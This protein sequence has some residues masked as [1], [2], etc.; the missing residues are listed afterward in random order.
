MPVM[1]GV[2]SYMNVED[3]RSLSPCAKSVLSWER[4][5]TSASISPFVSNQMVLFTN[6]IWHVGG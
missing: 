4:N 5:S 6:L 3:A 2:L 1:K